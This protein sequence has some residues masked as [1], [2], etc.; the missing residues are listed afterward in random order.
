MNR[1]A[2]SLLL[3][4]LLLSVSSALVSGQQGTDKG[5]SD[6][7]KSK[8]AP[9]KGKT[10]PET[11]KKVI[12]T[13]KEWAKLLTRTQYMVTRHKATEPAFTGKYVNNHATGVYHCVCCDEELFA[14]RTKFE[15]GTGWPSFYAPFKADRIAT[16]PDFSD[17]SEVRTEVECSIC[18][19]HLGHVFSDG[20][21]PT[22]L[23]YC[24]NSAALKFVKESA[25]AKAKAKPTAKPVAKT[26]D[27]THGDSTATDAQNSSA[28]SKASTKTKDA[29]TGAPATGESD[30]ATP[31]AKTKTSNKP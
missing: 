3:T 4:A 11:R 17:P 27:A 18:G 8:P 9:E 24:I 21:P 16:A 1:A 20:P 29:P 15:S 2:C 6:T 23:R 30:G 10:E 19:A 5:K 22:G 13:D 26:K 12:K 31:P 7:A 14:S 25:S 28:N